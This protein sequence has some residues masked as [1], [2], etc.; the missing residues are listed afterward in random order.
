MAF[1]G[2]KDLTKGDEL[3]TVV[4]FAIPLFLSNLLQQ[5]Y[6]LTDIT[7]IGNALGDDALTAIGTV[8]IIY[9]LFMSLTFGMSNG[10]AI[11]VSKYF[12]MNDEKKIRQVVDH[13]FDSL[14][15]K[16]GAGNAEIKK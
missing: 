10:F 7:I 16:Y 13:A 4:L 14:E 6:N 8:S 2:A 11:V 3:K 1:K 15:I 5:A 9:D 12:G